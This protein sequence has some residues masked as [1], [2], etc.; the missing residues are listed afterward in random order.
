M[1]FI[2][3][4]DRNGVWRHLNGTIQDVPEGSTDVRVGGRLVATP[5]IPQPKTQLKPLAWSSK[6][7][8]RF[9]RCVDEYGCGAW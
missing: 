7:E 2:E 8:D 3:Y 1:S 9:E 6:L 5:T 4:V